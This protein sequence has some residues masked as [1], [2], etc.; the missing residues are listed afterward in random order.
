MTQGFPTNAKSHRF[1]QI[2]YQHRMHPEISKFSREQFYN[3]KALLDANTISDRN[4]E[5]PF[6]YRNNQPRSIWLDVAS[7]VH[8]GV[9]DGEVK[10]VRSMLE[11][12]IEWARKNPPKNPR[13]DDTKRWEVALLSPYQAQRRGLRDMVRKLTGMSFETRFDLNQMPNPSQ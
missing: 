6:E 9:N 4:I 13:R 5:F 1:Q 3:D 8:G 12:F 10:A 2:S 11:G 7:G